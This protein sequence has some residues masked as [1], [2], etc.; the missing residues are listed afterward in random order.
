MGTDDLLVNN[1]VTE[2]LGNGETLLDQAKSVGD[3][4]RT[5][6]RDP[7]SGRKDGKDPTP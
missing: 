2:P 5:L 3:E 4:V 6:E 1:P 7:T